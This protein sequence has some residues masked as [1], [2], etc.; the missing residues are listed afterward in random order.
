MKVCV[1]PSAASEVAE[2]V[3]FVVSVNCSVSI[4]HLEILALSD[5]V[6]RRFHSQKVKTG[7][8]Y[9]YYSTRF[10]QVCSHPWRSSAASPRSTMVDVAAL[11]AAILMMFMRKPR[12]TLV[13]QLSQLH[14]QAE[15][16]SEERQLG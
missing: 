12:Q 2:A 1:V 8:R 13:R 10:I 14:K 16:K 11:V 15:V 4:T 3:G 5:L 9:R 7:T 6:G